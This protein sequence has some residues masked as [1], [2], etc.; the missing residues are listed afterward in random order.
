MAQ[1]ESRFITEDDYRDYRTRQDDDIRREFEKQS[2][3][4]DTGNKKLQDDLSS[5]ISTANEK[6]KYELSTTFNGMLS[7][8]LGELNDELGRV[9]D[10]LRDLKDEVKDE[11]GQVKDEVAEIKAQLSRIDG[12]S[13]NSSRWMPKHNIVS[14]GVYRPGIGF[15]QPTYFPSTLNAF[16]KLQRPYNSK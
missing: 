1:T 10:D 16:W 11:V 5:A 6:L 4:I 8:R 7:G 2:S 9:K 13:Y 14:I 12:Q 15:Q 3:F